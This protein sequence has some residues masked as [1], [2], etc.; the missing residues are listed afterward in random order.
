[1]AKSTPWIGHSGRRYKRRQI[2]KKLP[3]PHQDETDRVSQLLTDSPAVTTTTRSGCAIRKPA[4]FCQVLPLPGVLSFEGGGSVGYGE[5]RL[6]F[7]DSCELQD[8][9][10]ELE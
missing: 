5:T 1:M 10:L 7:R 3:P 9:S 2:R 8:S 4:R 6:R